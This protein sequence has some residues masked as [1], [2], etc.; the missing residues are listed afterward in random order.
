QLLAEESRNGKSADPTVW[1]DRLAVI[2]R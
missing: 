1:L 2:F